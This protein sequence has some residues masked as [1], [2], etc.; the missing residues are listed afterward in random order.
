MGGHRPVFFLKTSVE[1]LEEAWPPDNG[2]SHTYSRGD[3]GPSAVRR[4]KFIIPPRPLPF[5][6]THCQSPELDG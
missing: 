2:E 4:I 3:A 1:S 5:M 6:L